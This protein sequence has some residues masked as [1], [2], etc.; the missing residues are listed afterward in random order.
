MSHV[1]PFHVEFLLV[2]QR[3]L[4]DLGPII[5]IESW[6]VLVPANL[7][8][9]GDSLTDHSMDGLE[10]NSPLRA[11]RLLRSNG[12]TVDGREAQFPLEK[13]CSIL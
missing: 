12:D 5:M 8:K 1:D 4:P 2:L 6:E 10:A 9:K 7:S 3:P 11:L 13:G